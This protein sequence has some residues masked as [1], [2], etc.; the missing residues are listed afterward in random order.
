LNKWRGLFL[1]L[2]K[3]IY[4]F[5]TKKKKKTTTKNTLKYSIKKL[6]EHTGFVNTCNSARRGPDALISG[7]DDGSVKLWDLR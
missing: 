3:Y 2:T 6:K 5:Y 7:S 4:I 1:F